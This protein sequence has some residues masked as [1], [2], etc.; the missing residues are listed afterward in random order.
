MSSVSICKFPSSRPGLQPG[1]QGAGGG[2]LFGKDHPSRTLNRGESVSELG[3]LRRQS[4]DD[5]VLRVLGPIPADFY[6]PPFKTK[7]RAVP[8][9]RHVAGK[10]FWHCAKGQEAK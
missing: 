10:H 4:P 9:I 5:D 7:N 8:F 3:D 6:L 1:Q 2:D